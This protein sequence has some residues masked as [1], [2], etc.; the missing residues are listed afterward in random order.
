[1]SMNEYCGRFFIVMD[2]NGDLAF[3]ISDVWLIGKFIWL[4]PAKVVIGVLHSIPQFAAFF[5]IGCGTGEGWGGAIFSLFV[6]FIVY[7]IAG[8]AIE[9]A[10][11]T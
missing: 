11:S 4:L 7:A 3:T 8:V 9:G 5:E 10:S 2:M 6:W 1:M